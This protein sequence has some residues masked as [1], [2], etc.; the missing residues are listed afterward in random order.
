MERHYADGAL[1]MGSLGKFNQ[2]PWHAK[3]ARRSKYVENEQREA[4]A[5]LFQSCRLHRPGPVKE[6]QAYRVSVTIQMGAPLHPIRLY[7]RAVL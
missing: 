7:F 1:G 4:T 3:T 6:R 5:L 2:E